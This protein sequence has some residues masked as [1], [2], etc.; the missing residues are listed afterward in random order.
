MKLIND[1][2]KGNRGL[3]QERGLVGSHLILRKDD[4]VGKD[5]NHGLRRVCA[6]CVEGH[7]SDVCPASLFLSTNPGTVILCLGK[8]GCFE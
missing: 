2:Q 4:F 7:G 8:I 5:K 1:L 3:P 6:F